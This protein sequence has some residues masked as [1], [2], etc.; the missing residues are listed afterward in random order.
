MNRVDL[1]KPLAYP[2]RVAVLILRYRPFVPFQNSLESPI[3]LGLLMKGKPVELNKQEEHK[4][5]NAH[6]S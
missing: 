4:P 3:P 5:D 6:V 2:L 1:H